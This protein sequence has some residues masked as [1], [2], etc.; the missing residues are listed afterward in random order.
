MGKSTVA[1]RLAHLPHFKLIRLEL[2]VGDVLL[3]SGDCVHAGDRGLDKKPSLRVH[4]YVMNY[5]KTDDTNIL[6]VFGKEFAS[7]F[8]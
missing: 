8:E 5:E 3:L 7:H 1:E 2:A 6:E 4:W